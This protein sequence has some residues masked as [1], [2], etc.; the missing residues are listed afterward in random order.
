M[1]P[2]KRS[3]GRSARSRAGRGRVLHR[4]QRSAEAAK[5]ALSDFKG[6][7][8]ADGYG[9]Y[10]SLAKAPGS[11]ILANCWTHV[12]RKYLDVEHA[13]PAQVKAIVDFIGE[14]YAADRLCPTGPPGDDL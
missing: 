12:R 9:V 5:K 13:F 11:F 7:V 3:S 10:E 8:M 2:A 6:A 14:L 1:T 4:G